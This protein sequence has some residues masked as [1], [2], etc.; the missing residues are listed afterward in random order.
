M[1]IHFNITG[2][3][4]LREDILDKIELRNAHFYLWCLQEVDFVTL[5]RE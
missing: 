1:I 5:K 3:L 4:K 2:L